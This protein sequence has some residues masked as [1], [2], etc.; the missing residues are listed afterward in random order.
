[1]NN[2][3]RRIFNILKT[4]E[5]SLDA[6]TLPKSFSLWRIRQE[7][8]VQQI[9][10]CL[11]LTVC[12]KHMYSLAKFKA[13]GQ[14]CMVQLNTVFYALIY[15][16]RARFYIVLFVFYLIQL[17]CTWLTHFVLL[18]HLLSWKNSPGGTGPCSIKF[19]KQKDHKATYI[20]S[21]NNS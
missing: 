11:T 18:Q 8:M 4:K 16:F 9:N 7:M 14:Q 6:T 20:A 19:I 3:K 15:W 2:N 21:N 12:V 5:M 1:M 13:Q 17:H 10:M